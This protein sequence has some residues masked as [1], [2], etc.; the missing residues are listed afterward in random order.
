MGLGQP[1]ASEKVDGVKAWINFSTSIV[2]GERTE[3]L[4][5]Q[6]LVNKDRVFLGNSVGLRRGITSVDDTLT[7]RDDAPGARKKYRSRMIDLLGKS[8]FHA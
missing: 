8:H 5:A 7:A 4:D 2:A 6:A 3:I 1:N